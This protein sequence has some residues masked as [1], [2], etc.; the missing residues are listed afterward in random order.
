[1]LAVLRRFGTA[2]PSVS[3]AVVVFYLKLDTGSRRKNGY[4]IIGIIPFAQ[5]RGGGV[6]VGGGRVRVGSGD[7]GGHHTEKKEAQTLHDVDF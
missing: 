7:H 2:E 3:S 4:K 1:M 6:P 5:G